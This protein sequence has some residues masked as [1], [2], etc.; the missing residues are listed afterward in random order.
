MSIA[1]E[2]WV[3]HRARPGETGPARLALETIA[4]RDLRDDSSSPSRS[5]AAGRAT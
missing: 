4:L 5:T 1:T 2:V 3:L